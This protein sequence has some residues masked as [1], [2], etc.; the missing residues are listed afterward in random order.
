MILYKYLFYFRQMQN[1]FDLEYFKNKLATR[2]NSIATLEQSVMSGISFW[3][4]NP[5]DPSTR[6]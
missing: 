3:D 6:A 5:L 2:A 1:L 4:P